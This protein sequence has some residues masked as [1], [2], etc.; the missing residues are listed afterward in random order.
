ME[1][2]PFR[3]P[4]KSGLFTESTER[5]AVGRW[6][7]GN[8]V[9]F[10]KGMPQKLG[11]W[12]E[13]ALTGGPIIGKGRR[14]HEWQSLDRQVWTAIGTNTKL[15]LVN[16][17]QLFDITPQRRQVTR[18]DPFTTTGASSTVTVH[19]EGHDAFQGDYVRISGASAVGG[20]TPDGEYR[21]VAV[22]GVD[23]YQIDVGTPA[24]GGFTGGG[25]VTFQY[26][27]NNGGEDTGLYY[28]WG[29]CTWNESTWGTPR[30]DCS[31]MIAPLRIWSLDNWGE[32][33]I[34]SP[35]G[36][37]VYWW[38]RTLGYNSRAQLIPT[39]PLTNQRVLVS[40]QDRQIICLGAYN[41]ESPDP[42]LI[43]VSDRGTFNFGPATSQNRVFT[44]RIDV[45]SK[46]ITGIRIRRNTIIFTDI[47]VHL[48]QPTNDAKVFD[49]AQIAEKNAIIGPNA[50]VVVDGE[51][52]LMGLDK[53][54]FYDG[55]YGELECEIWTKVFGEE[56]GG[57]NRAQAYKVYAWYN[58]VFGEVWWHYPSA[59][60]NECDRVAIYSVDEEHWTFATLSRTAG[61]DR[62]S[63]ERYPYA[64]TP[65]GEM[66]LHENGR[67]DNGAALSCFLESY[68]V[69]L[70]E[71]KET[72]HVARAI[73]DFKVLAGAFSL[74]LKTKKQ[75]ETAAYTV[76]GP[77]QFVPGTAAKGVRAR[78]RL[79]A[80]R[81][82]STALGDHWR[83]GD[84]SFVGQPDNKRGV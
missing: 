34:A 10:H 13:Q 78:G 71:G 60:S 44:K 42:L 6:K 43:R 8:N 59:G 45:G 51:A 64:L 39:A 63:V 49:V 69:M 21:V 53:F 67:D 9:R 41:G 15:Y 80:F 11:G 79:F 27:I 37:A 83:A 22:L 72:I 4:I 70:G 28:G 25:N 46:I 75:P 47:S 76:K 36:G 14:I 62:G 77:Y 32:D 35:S 19:D 29:T 56:A 38:N 1:R 54:H 73:A 30:G 48:M 58:S 66:M 68:D 40:P 24:A 31:T 33:L 17:N 3:S 20:V 65:D 57:F 2:E 12:N 55:V 23:D 26:D 16:Q 52:Y 50:A 5:N 82:E 84:F 7:D 81:Y 61:H 18:T 74:T